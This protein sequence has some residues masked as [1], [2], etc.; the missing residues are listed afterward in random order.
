M[1]SQ[2]FDSISTFFFY[3]LLFSYLSFV[4]NDDLIKKR[5]LMK[6]KNLF[7]SKKFLFLN[8]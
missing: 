8:S 6:E 2:S 5:L 7:G 3:N 1:Q 4:L